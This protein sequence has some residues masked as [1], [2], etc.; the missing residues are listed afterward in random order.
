MKCSIL[1][2][3]LVKTAACCTKLKALQMYYPGTIELTILK[4]HSKPKL[5]DN[6]PYMSP[7]CKVEVIKHALRYSELYS[8]SIDN[9]SDSYNQT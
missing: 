1:F 2:T 7:N 5:S 9:K 8:F 4:K 3:T 6:P